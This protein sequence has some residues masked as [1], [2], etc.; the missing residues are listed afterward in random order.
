MNTAHTPSGHDDQSQEDI[1]IA[2][3]GL[4]FAWI[5][6]YRSHPKGDVPHWDNAYNLKVEAILG[7]IN[8]FNGAGAANLAGYNPAAATPRVVCSPRAARHEQSAPNPVRRWGAWEF[9]SLDDRRAPGPRAP[10]NPVTA[11]TARRAR[12]WLATSGLLPASFSGSPSMGAPA[13]FG[14]KARLR[15]AETVDL[16]KL[17][18]MTTSAIGSRS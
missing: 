8:V 5:R 2:G 11:T 12:D 10:R 3:R 14:T 6:T 9:R 18:A 16:N 4:D 7:D 15:R 17:M 1:R 13:R